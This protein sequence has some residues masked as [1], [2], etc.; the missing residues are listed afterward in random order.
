[1]MLKRWDIMCH[2][3]GEW[4]AGKEFLVYNIGLIQKPQRL[5]DIAAV[6]L[7]LLTIKLRRAD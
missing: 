6:V 1:M 2:L 4:L 5:M 3:L 7:I